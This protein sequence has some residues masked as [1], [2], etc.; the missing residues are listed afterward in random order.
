ML[1]VLF[2][3]DERELGPLALD[4]PPSV[5]RAAFMGS[6]PLGLP[7]LL[8]DYRVSR[9]VVASAMQR[10]RGHVFGA[11]R[12]SHDDGERR[13]HVFV[14][15]ETGRG[16]RWQLNGYHRP[17]NP[18]LSKRSDVISFRRM[19]TPF[20]FTRLSVP[21]ML[22]RAGTRDVSR[23]NEGSMVAA[24]KE[25]GFRTA[26]I[27]MQA[28]LGFHESMVSSYAGEADLV[29]FLNP[30]DYS[31]HGS[32]D[33]KGVDTVMEY[34]EQ[35]PVDADLFIVLHTL[36]SHF[37]YTDRYPAEEAYFLPDNAPDRRVGLY[38]PEDAV[39]LSNAY[40][41]SLRYTDKV[42]NAL[43]DRLDALHA[44]SWV[45]YSADHGEALFDG[46]DGSAGHGQFNAQ[47]Q[48]VAAAFW[49]SPEYAMRH[50]GKLDTLRQRAE[51]PLSTLMV[52]ETLTSLGDVGVPG[53]RT[54]Y[55]F[56][57]SD[58]VAAPPA[59]RYAACE[60]AAQQGR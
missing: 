49:S 27:S 23:F 5:A 12:L 28:P 36:G 2:E 50:A 4:A 8:H 17:T 48:S 31:A 11:K 42:L 14:I 20:V 15:G 7:V 9:Q 54:G 55:D 34:I 16:S 56:S 38:A 32:P 22:T 18:Y 40:D 60:V 47:T 33:M 51:T 26:W 58:Q 29:R 46:C 21:A 37:R 35:Q 10:K 45:Y 19:T 41:N 57:A 53:Q 59:L 25:A 44:Q 30:V 1:L 6:Y 39:Y 13:I 43:F 24:F 52:F 3:P